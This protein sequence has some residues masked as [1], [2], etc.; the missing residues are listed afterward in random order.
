MA[1]I[2]DSQERRTDKPQWYDPLGPNAK[3]QLQG[4]TG[5]PEWRNYIYGQM[6]GMQPALQAISKETAG[7][8]YGAAND[9]GWGAL[10]NNAR[11]NAAGDWLGGGSA[12]NSALQNFSQT[13][14]QAPNQAYADTLAGNF[15]TRQLPQG[16]QR[17]FQPTS[18]ATESALGR[19]GDQTGQ[20]NAVT[21]GTLAGRYLNAGPRINANE[22]SGAIRQRAG[23]EAA[24]TGANIRSSFGR[25]GMGFSTANQQAQQANQAASSARANELESQTRFAA[26]QS[27]L[28]AYGRE[29]ALQA[30][31]A[32]NEDAAQRALGM[33]GAQSRI[34]ADQFDQ[35]I[36]A[37]RDA[38]ERGLQ[39]ENYGRERMMQ[40]QTSMDDAGAK[41]D[42]NAYE[43]GARIQNYGAERAYQNNAAQQLSAALGNPLQYLSQIPSTFM[44]PLSQVAQMVQGLSGGG[45]MQ[46]AQSQFYKDEGILNGVMGGMGALGAG[47]AGG[48]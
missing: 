44:G 40:Q 23:A 39:A 30:G 35:G 43:T 10:A 13:A 48:F 36:N 27:N 21:Q 41:R 28:D 42:A 14:N 15:T 3:G 1:E 31:A 34:G 12:F 32:V 11:S 29:R 18:R 24:D 19:L 25:A 47:A 20:A 9:P 8:A 7:R 37:G 5:G 33:F 6:G 22:I 45:P 16:P 4:P 46:T 26:D 2:C 17:S 38:Q